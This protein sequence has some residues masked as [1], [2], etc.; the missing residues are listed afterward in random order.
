MKNLQQFQHE[1][2]LPSYRRLAFKQKQ[3]KLENENEI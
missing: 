2:S 1:F 3:N